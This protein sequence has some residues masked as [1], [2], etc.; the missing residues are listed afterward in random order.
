[1]SEKR[2]VHTATLLRDGRVLI[3]GGVAY[4]GI[5]IFLG[6]LVSAEIY[7]PAMLVPAPV[8]TS[9]SEK[10][11]GA[12]FH[13]GTPH[14]AAPDDP[15]ESGDILDISCTGLS[16]ESAMLPHVSIGGRIVGIVSVTGS[17]GSCRI[18]VRVPSGIAAGSSVPVRLIYFGRPSNDVTIAVR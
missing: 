11:Q 3:A 4:G 6:S 15:A 18:R 16:R 1:M 8:L 2:E 9:L 12:I 17:P 10:G 13:A 5:G 7:T 14:V